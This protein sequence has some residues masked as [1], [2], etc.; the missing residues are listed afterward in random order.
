VKKN[1]FLA[2]SLR[3]KVIRALVVSLFFVAAL[4]NL[5]IYK[6]SQDAQFEQ[7]RK[8]LITI[9]QV[10][11]LTV[12]ADTLIN[13]PLNKEGVNSQ[14][15]KAI[16]E[17]LLQVK[18][19]NSSIL[20]IYT[21]TRTDKDGIWQFVVDP[22]PV[23]KSKNRQDLNSYPGDRYDVSRL[24]DM[25]KAFERASADRKLMVD[26]WGVTLSGY[27]PI[28]DKSGKAVAVLGIDISAQD[29]YNMERELNQ[30][31]FIVLAIGI[32][33]SFILG[34]WVSRRI[35]QP[36]KQLQD[37]T[38]R[39]AAG[40]LE[41]RVDIKGADE[42]SCLGNSFNSMAKH[43]SES[44]KALQDYFYRIV[45]SLVRS[46]EAKDSYTRGHSDRVAE[47]SEQIA[48]KMGFS[49]EESGMLKKVAQLHDIGKIGIDERI[50]NKTEKLIDAEWQ[51]IKEH[52]AIG[53][54]ILSPVFLDKKLLN[55]VRHHHERYDG[56]G[57][58]DGLKGE[59]TDILAQIVCVADAF[60]AMT[61][62]RAYRDS[63]MKDVA[64]V[65]LKKNSG[66]QFNPRVVE[67]FL[68]IAERM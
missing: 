29:V 23:F 40:D 52:P 13:V 58:P 63:F 59:A 37:A 50:L 67:A 38:S 64:I 49:Q 32:L 12:D 33:M 11:S 44:K 19:A 22:Q 34:L 46:L 48:L 60:D 53:E 65:E 9:A 2:S 3:A 17:K 26:K 57:Y 31:A 39:I 6:A 25:S 28:R 68:K 7:L 10:I 5:L 8:S 47:F 1:I 16:A 20:F 51:I 61:S 15:Y 36:V 41:Y 35:T 27:A 4:S 56:K 66:T 54:E 18:N 55:I 42:I 21:L 24:P 43:L 45:Q 62:N 30:R 14:Q